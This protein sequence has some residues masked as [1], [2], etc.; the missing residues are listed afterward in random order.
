MN[1]PI[2]LYSRSSDRNP[3]SCSGRWKASGKKLRGKDTM[4]PEILRT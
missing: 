4:S 1:Y 3:A 2:W